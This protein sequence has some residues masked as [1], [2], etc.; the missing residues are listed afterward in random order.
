MSDRLAALRLFTRVARTGS[1]SQAGREFELSQP[2][3]S[4]IVAELEREVGVAL[5]TRTTRAVTLTEAGT[6]YLARIEPLLA[7]L[8]EADHA[9]RGTGEIRGLLRVGLS[10]SFAVRAVIP[11]LPPFVAAHGEL[12][13]DLLMN[14][15]RQDLLGDGVDV[16]LRFGPLPDTSATAR[17]IGAVPR[18]LAAAPAYLERAGVPKSPADLGDHAIVLGPIGSDPAAWTMRRGDESVTAR[19]EG[20]LRISANEGAIAAAVAGLGIVSTGW[21]GCLAELRSG[22]LVR[23]LEDW[24][25]EA[26]DIYAVFPAGRATKPAARAFI[27][28]LIQELSE[29]EAGQGACV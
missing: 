15:Q 4:R 24:E 14:D 1:F 3:A 27:D 19:V 23:V 11:L 7:E 2:S 6:E 22:A 9:A 13:I 10:S 12:R 20:R 8:E 17:R 26:T 25:I 16:A 18:L 5:F 21:W 29:L 28:Y